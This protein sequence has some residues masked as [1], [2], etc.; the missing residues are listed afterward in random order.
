MSETPSWWD[1]MRARVAAAGRQALIG[2]AAQLLAAY[3][4][5]TGW[6]PA[7][8]AARVDSGTNWVLEALAQLPPQDVGRAR[9]AFQQV[10]A[11]LTDQD[12]WELLKHDALHLRHHAHMLA[13][14]DPSR[15]PRTL[16]CFRQAQAWLAG[17]GNPPGGPPARA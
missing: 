5:E 9:W 4:N 6:T 13:L 7:E 16:A 1:Q 12:I 14:A 11:G 17:G 2:Q 8:L 3:L 15:W 10:A